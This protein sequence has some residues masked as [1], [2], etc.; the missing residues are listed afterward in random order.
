MRRPLV[1]LVPIVLLAAALRFTGLDWG[2]RHPPHND[3][4]SFVENAEHM[5]RA[6]TL[7][8]R[9]YEYPALFLYLLVPVQAAAGDG[10]GAY[11]AARGL[12]ASFGVLSVGLVGLIGMRR[13]GAWAG[14]SA[15]ALL[16]VSPLEVITA[17]E[18]RPDVALE[19]FALVALASLWALDER[20]RTD[21]RAG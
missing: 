8:H 17:H 19:S 2:L 1:L 10:P 21:L 18:V 20:R 3:E 4:R 12:V 6:R 11:L 5:L 14:L 16:A 13:F 15:A 7:D 9:F